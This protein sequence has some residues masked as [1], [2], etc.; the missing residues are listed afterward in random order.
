[1][2]R[3]PISAG[4]SVDQTDD[5]KAVSARAHS[6][7]IDRTTAIVKDESYWLDGIFQNWVRWMHSDELP[8]GLPDKGC[9]GIVGYVSGGYDHGESYEAID[10]RVA[11]IT[12]AVIESLDASEQAAIYSRYLHAVFRFQRQQDVLEQARAHVAEGLKRRGVWLGE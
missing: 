8:E 3:T 1:M 4:G 9:G 6:S 2:R 7:L 11:E 5:D 12:N 10:A